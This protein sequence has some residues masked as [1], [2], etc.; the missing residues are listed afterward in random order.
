[1]TSKQQLATELKTIEEL[2]EELNR[3]A[4]KIRRDLKAAETPPAPPIYESM[5]KLVV[6]FDRNGPEY[7]YLLMRF[8]GKFYTTGTQENQKV[9]KDWEALVTW[10]REETYAH[11]ELVA[12]HTSGQS[13]RT[14][15]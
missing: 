7:T 3:R 9:F 15:A 6:R 10:L 1:M 8:G 2:R 4:A 14:S 11:S 12:L 13:Y 5:F